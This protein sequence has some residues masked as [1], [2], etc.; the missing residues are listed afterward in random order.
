MSEDTDRADPLG[1]LADFTPGPKAPSV[2]RDTIRYVSKLA[3]SARGLLG[4]GGRDGIRN[5]T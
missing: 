1:D 3:G 4:G 2:A 5:S